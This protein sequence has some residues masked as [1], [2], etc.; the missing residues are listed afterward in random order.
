MILRNGLGNTIAFLF[1]KGK[2]EH[3]EVVYILSKWLI[4]FS[5]LHRKD[6]EIN[7]ERIVGPQGE[8]LRS[9]VTRVSVEEYMYYTEKSI[10]S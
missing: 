9:L 4:N 2:E 3:S 10:R 7:R 5:D 6:I 1:S 8:I